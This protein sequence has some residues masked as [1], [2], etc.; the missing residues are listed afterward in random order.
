[1]TDPHTGE[2]YFLIGPKTLFSVFILV[3]GVE[4]GRGRG[5][6]GGGSGDNKKGRCLRI[7][8]SLAMQAATSTLLPF[9]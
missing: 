4:C 1:M 7:A 8:F 5:G 9:I 6:G 3:C 2:C